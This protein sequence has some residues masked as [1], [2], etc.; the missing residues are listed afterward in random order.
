MSDYIVF[1]GADSRTY[2]IEVFENDTYSAGSAVVSAV[3]VPGRSGDVLIPENRYANIVRSY[4]CVLHEDAVDNYT[5]FRAFLLSQMGY[6]TLI[7]SKY[8]DHFFEGYVSSSLQPKLTPEAGMIK[9]KLS[10]NC[11]PQRFLTS[12]L[13]V[14]TLTEDDIIENPTLYPSAP[15]MKVTG[16]G[17]LGINSE[18]VVIA[19]TYPQLGYMYIDFDSGRCYCNG[20]SMDEQVTFPG[21]DLPKLL[22]GENTITLTGITAVEIVPRW[23]TL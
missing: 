1:A 13:E 20:Q 15:L 3:S 2:G 8:P 6:K 16:T 11:K 19:N 14:T 9:F 4:D 7:D 23:W 5:A 22:P 18:N 17:T 12:G 21:Y 10:F